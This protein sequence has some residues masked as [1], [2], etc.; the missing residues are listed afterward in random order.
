MKGRCWC[1]TINFGDQSSYEDIDPSE[2]KGCVVAVWQHEVGDSGTEHLQGYV[3]FSVSMRRAAV[4]KLSGMG[5]AYLEL[6]RGT[7]AE[8][9]AYCTKEEGRL[10][11][12]FY[13]PSKQKVETYCSIENGGRTDLSRLCE[14]VVEGN[15][16]REIAAMNPIY[17]LRFQKHI[18]H[19]RTA[20]A[21]S[22]RLGDELDVVVYV[23]PTGTGKSRRLRLECP[24]G[25]DWFWA[26]PGKW[27][28]GY[29]GQPGV[30]LD[31][32][33]HDWYRYHEL[34]RLLDTGPYRVEKKG[35]HVNMRAYRFRFSSNVHP[36][37][38]YPNVVKPAWDESPLARR[39]PYIE[40]MLDQHVVEGPRFD[41]ARAW[42]ALQP[43]AVAPAARAA[44]GQRMDG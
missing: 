7:K 2:W 19:L 39:M 21:E 12:P 3:N 40:L 25:P 16:D 44:Y 23:G 41:N 14:L 36:E 4:S 24:E 34:L 35:G 9:L 18:D 13:F 26:V 15:T 32:F 42:A 38:W 43:D 8:N 5:R 6:R 30:V 27:F 20:V 11:G 33:R 22:T 37:Y 29:Q 17:I 28:D 10:D 31:E 1:F